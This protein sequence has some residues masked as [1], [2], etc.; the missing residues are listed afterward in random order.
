MSAPTHTPD[1]I[2]KVRAAGLTDPPQDCDWPFCGCD[3]YADK[4][5][6]AV[7][8]SHHFEFKKGVE[9]VRYLRC[10]AHLAVPQICSTL[11]GEECGECA[12]LTGVN[13]VK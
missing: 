6:E 7:M 5:L 10:I 9:S 1:F 3:P 4:V 11:I 12:R 8:E 2:C 13:E